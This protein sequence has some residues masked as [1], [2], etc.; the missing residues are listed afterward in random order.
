MARDWDSQDAW[1][2]EDKAEQP[3]STG[4][5]GRLQRLKNAP[6][7]KEHPNLVKGVGV[8]VLLLLMMLLLAQQ[9]HWFGGDEPVAPPV[10]Q[11]PQQQGQQ[12]QPG[13][14]AQ[15]ATLASKVAPATSAKELPKSADKNPPKP[16]E[17]GTVKPEEN[18]PLPDDVAKWK[19][20]DYFRARR[21]NDPKLAEAVASLSAKTRGSA[22]RRKD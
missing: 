9:M 18:R 16:A 4:L 15:P 7:L 10:A 3:Q 5:A 1:E 17:P 22:R 14:A 8:G 13:P 20:D 2:E 12:G 11:Q 21:E 19:K 6:W